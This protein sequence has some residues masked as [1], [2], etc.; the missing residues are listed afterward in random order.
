M[1]IGNLFISF[2]ISLAITFFFVPLCAKLAR[3]L[4]IL[5]IP[6]GKIKKHSAPIPYLGGVA[7]YCGFLFG[8]MIGSNFE[9][10]VISVIMASSPF[11]ILGLIDD[12]TVLKPYQKFL[13]Q[14]IIACFFLKSGI[15]LHQLLNYWQ[16]L[17]LLFWILLI[18]NA[19]NLVDVMDGLA[20]TIASCAT[21]SFLIIALAFN[22]YTLGVVLAAFLGSLLAF[23]FYNK[24]QA[25]IYMGDAGSLYIGGVLSI[26]PF[27]FPSNNNPYNFLVPIIILTIPLLEVVALI[28]IR[29][30]KKIPFYK[31]S[32]DHFS[33]Y[34]TQ[35]GWSKTQILLYVI[36]F[37][38]V[39]LF[40][41][42]LLAF[43]KLT[44]FN[45]IFLQTVIIIVWFFMLKKKYILS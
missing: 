35:S 25:S 17:T 22:Y 30:S 8:L 34:L 4:G 6:D 37:A 24:P 32:P 9:R 41:A 7:L 36:F 26:I 38:S 31:P 3:F 14:V 10:E 42:L 15:C 5:D 16:F 33:M 29:S 12:L 21:F 43:N 45:L 23:L 28:I 1:G 18:T 13:G 2:F 39:L 40:V 20:T 19:F 11:L 44:I 27:L